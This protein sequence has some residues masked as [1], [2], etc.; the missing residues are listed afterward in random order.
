MGLG[1]GRFWIVTALSLSACGTAQPQGNEAVVQNATAAVQPPAEHFTT[2]CWAAGKSLEQDA[3]GL[4]VRAEPDAA[5]AI[6][7]VLQS[8]VDPESHRW[9]GPP[10]YYGPG[11]RIVDVRGD[12][13]KID[14]TDPLS[15][16]LGD[17][18]P[19]YTGPGWVHSRGVVADL[20]RPGEAIDGPARAGPEESAAVIDADGALNA[21]GD[22]DAKLIDCRGE[23]VQID[24]RV[25]SRR[26]AAGKWIDLTPAELAK[27]APTRGWLRS[28]PF[29]TNITCESG[30]LKCLP[31]GSVNWNA[32]FGYE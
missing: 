18:I 13:V 2:R 17:D 10:E 5:S 8:V 24:Y 6:L 3:K 16:G 7:G 30:A 29:R 9:P 26:D 27:V 21:Y 20:Q 19:N 23:W 25:T 14:G 12:W 4:N 31:D 1:G 22:H 11:F 32:T 28:Y 15:D